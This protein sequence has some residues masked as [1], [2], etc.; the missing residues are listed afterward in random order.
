MDEIEV[1]FYIEGLGND[2]KVLESALKETAEKLRRDKSLEIVDLKMEDVI[3]NSETET[4]KYSGMIEARLKGTLEAITIAAI[5]YA[6]AVVDIISPGKIEIT[7]EELMKVLGKVSYMMGELMEKF[8]PLAA[9]P[10]FDE[11]PEPKIGYTRDEIEEFIFNER[12]IVYRFVVEAY[13]NDEEEVK[14]GLAKGLE[15]E[16]CKINKLVTK[17]QEENR[18]RKYILI[19]LEL[20]SSF[21][22]LFQLTAKYAPVA[23][24]I[25]EPEIIDVTAYELQG[26]LVD[27][28]GFAYEL[29]T[30]PLKEKIIEKETF[31]FKL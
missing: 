2:K 12:M 4:L 1:I 5:K 28:A 15:Y 11:L 23:I 14:I 9:Y 6:P 16:G 20:V 22:T 21:E 29:T 30:R 17:V 24:S 13:G 18:G 31:K 8:G 7:A 27:L 3:E 19:A 26:A 25:I 10:K